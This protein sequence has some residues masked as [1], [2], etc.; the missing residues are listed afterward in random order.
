MPA[1][2]LPTSQEQTSN[3][4]NSNEASLRL[5]DKLSL[6]PVQQVKPDLNATHTA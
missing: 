4:S 6:V 3:V 1:A 5:Y 2:D